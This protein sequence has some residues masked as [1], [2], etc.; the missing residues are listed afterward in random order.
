M[1]RILYFFVLLITINYLL[2]TDTHA[3]ST[4]PVSEN[5]NTVPLYDIYELTINHPASFSNPWT[6]GPNPWSDVV[7]DTT[8]THESGSPSYQIGGFYYDTDT[9]KVR[10]TPTQEGRWDWDLTLTEGP[11][12]FTQTGSFN[13]ISSQNTGFLR[14]H[15]QNKKRLYTDADNKFFFPMGIGG[16]MNDWYDA[17]TCGCGVIICPWDPI[18]GNQDNTLSCDWI[19]RYDPYTIHD[20]PNRVDPTSVSIDEYFG[21]FKT[22]KYNF[23]RLNTGTDGLPQLWQINSGGTGKNV[24]YVDNGKLMDEL[25][26]K[27]HSLDIKPYMVFDAIRYSGSI[28]DCNIQTDPTLKQAVY[29][30]H[31]YFIDRWG[32]YVSIWELINE[33][34]PCDYYYDDISQFIKNYDSYDHII[35]TNWVPPNWRGTPD[36][37]KHPNIDIYSEH[38]YG[39]SH[40]YRDINRR[41]FTSGASGKVDIHGEWGNKC[42]G[43]GPNTPI[44]YRFL[45]WS[46]FA[47]EYTIVPW[48]SGD[49]RTDC[50]FGANG[51]QNYNVGPNQRSYVTIL[52]NLVEDF[53]ILAKPQIV[54]SSAN[55]MASAIGSNND[56][57]VYV[58]NYETS[59]TFDEN[60]LTCSP[61]ISNATVIVDIPSSL[62]GVQ[63]YW[64]EPATGNHLQN[65]VAKSGQ[66]SYLVPNFDCDIALVI[67]SSSQQSTSTP[68]PPTLTSI[69]VP[70]DADEDGDVDLTDYSIWITQYLNYNPTQNA[71]PDFNTDQ[72]VDGEDFVIWLN[73]YGN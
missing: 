45:I 53:D 11:T 71:D 52:A 34:T 8:F 43:L 46:G 54:T 22:A 7:I 14:V 70:G 58:T 28:F 19:L 38:Q 32:A 73:N 41:G 64:L 16:A 72:E 12:M 66:Q 27:L 26:D 9:F 31:K 18:C 6:P 33:R 37:T 59:A 23:Y 13:G 1:R 35:S 68:P 63:G 60:T 55:I 5:K 42:P 39:G 47:K 40:D 69:P 62:D 20:C 65:I 15:P 51:R 30:H 56:V 36:W 25:M 24:F 2:V 4:I 44:M 10:F 57:L 50:S 67:N 61:A 17:S 48:W 3:Q 21:T 49:T 29:D